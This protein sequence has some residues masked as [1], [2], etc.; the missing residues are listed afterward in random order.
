MRSKLGLHCKFSD[1]GRL[2]DAMFEL[3]LQNKTDYT[4]FMRQLSQLDTDG[5]QAV[6]DLFI[7][8]EAAS[9]WLD[10][11]LARCERETGAD[12]QR[13]TDAQ[14][15]EKM[16]QVNPHYVLRNYL[17]QMAIEKAEQGDF[18]EVNQLAALLRSPYEAQAGMEAYANLPPQWGKDMEISC[19]S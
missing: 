19:S 18:S 12:D 5:K 3:L 16:R 9:A 13:I 6:I 11:Y 8:R 2:F 1:D 14:R 7:D 10:Q 15:C 17:A 4:R